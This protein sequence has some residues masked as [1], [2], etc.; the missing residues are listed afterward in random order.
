[1]IDAYE[2]KLTNLM[3]ENFDDV[4]DAGTAQGKR[5]LLMNRLIQEYS[6]IVSDA[7]PEFEDATASATYSFKR[8]ARIELDHFRGFTRN[9][10]ISFDKDYTFIYGPNGSGKSSF[11]EALEYAMLG[12]IDEAINRRIDIDQYIRNSFTGISQNPRLVGFASDE[13]EIPLLPNP[14]MFNF[15]FIEKNRIEDFGRISAN[16][17][18]DRQNLLSALFGHSEFND[19]VGNFTNNIEKYL[20]VEGKAGQELKRLSA[21]IEVQRKNVEKAKQ[22]LAA[23]EQSKAQFAE[24]SGL[25]MDFTALE[26]F[27]HGG[28]DNQGRLADLNIL[29]SSPL[30][31]KFK[32]AG[33]EDI[34]KVISSLN[35]DVGN[36]Q[37][38]YE[39]YTQNRDKVQFRA[40]YAAT[41]ELQKVSAEKCPVC[42]TPIDIATKHPFENA[43]AKLKELEQISILETQLQQ[44]TIDLSHKIELFST[45]LQERQRAAMAFRIDAN[46]PTFVP[47]PLD[48]PY[49]FP[50]MVTNFQ[51]VLESWQASRPQNLEIDNLITK[52]NKNVCELTTDRS[53]FEEERKKLL[54]LSKP[55]T[56]L[57]TQIMAL[58][59]QVATWKKEI[60]EFAL[61][62]AALIKKAQDELAVILENQKFAR[63]YHNFLLRLS[64]YRDELPIRHLRELNSL[65][66]EIYN[67]INEG[68]RHFEKVAN[69]T[70]PST[71][72]DSIGIVFSD[73]PD[74]KVDALHVLSEGH[75]RCLGL[76][77]LLAKNIHEKTPL[78]IFDDVVNAIDDDHR[79]GVRNVVF[80]R[81]YM[82]NKQV[83]LTTHAEQFVKELE[84]HLSKPEYDKLVQKLSFFI[85]AQERLIRIK[86]D[87]QQNYL[88]KI[89]KACTEAEW[90]E[91]L[92]NSRCCLESLTNK[93]WQRLGKRSLKTEFSVIIRMPNGKPD[94]MSVVASLN[95]FLKKIDNTGAFD[96]ICNIFGYLLGLESASTIVW[97]YL[98]KGTHEEE[99][100]PE[101]DH[102]I[103][104]EI[105]KKL[106]KLDLQIKAI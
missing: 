41:I 75:I 28:D 51:S 98:N 38:L 71:K 91:A 23:F 95:K 99:G 100:R 57:N 84:Q 76:A 106:I 47:P 15:C 40:L 46:L 78:V 2:R 36:S 16:T 52:H 34:D 25:G 74:H 44:A 90:S 14:S 86:N 88:H 3:L 37:R 70:L 33:T 92:Y 69:I 101:F 53:K 22:D 12:Y 56:A 19:F 104:T 77:I 21:G 7:L 60:D 102:V 17:P 5:G 29:L 20:D 31:S 65:T 67:I 58:Q 43:K 24:A 97:Q 54:D 13:S 66:A 61:K 62:N 30:P 85:D 39:E 64:S 59:K 8:L 87:A 80:S 96:G 105:S 9:E 103:V 49:S 89:E 45:A 48:G 79:S 83:I 94:L 10:I 72:N 32:L 4:A 11:C 63:A 35:T 93:L 6:S 68:D 55:I 18:N 81:K 27:I 1:M 26:A 42:E 73:K 50:A 82:E